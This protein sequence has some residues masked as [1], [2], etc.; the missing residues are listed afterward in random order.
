MI[1]KTNFLN[2]L[3]NL[4]KRYR[5][6]SQIWIILF[7]SAIIGIISGLGAILFH[8]ILELS[9]YFFL[10]FLAGYYP[11]GPGGEA[12]LFPELHTKIN[13]WVLL[14]IPAI[15]AGL[16]GIIVYWLAPEAE[17][18]GTDAAID[19]YHH[20][21]GDVR[22]IVPFVKIIASALTIGSGGSAGREGP[23]AQ[24]GSGFGSLLGKWLKL[25]GGQRRILM[26]AGV[27]GGI[28]AIFHAPIAG[29]LFASEVLYRNIDFEYEA[30]FPASI[31]SIIAYSVYTS[32]YGWDPLFKIP[33]FIFS[34]PLQLIP[35]LVLAV[36]LA[37]GAIL[38][39]KT[40]YGIHDLFK[41]LPVPK[42]IKPAIGGLL[43]G[44]IGFFLPEALGTGY[45]TIQNALFGKVSIIL[46]ILM[47]FAKIATT[48]FTVGSG[49]SGGIFGPA[50]V[51]GG[52]IGGVVGILFQQYFPIFQINSGTFV[53]VAS[54]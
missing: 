51:I 32:V 43:T 2:S 1:N 41:K 29:A 20:K 12:S 18:H 37:L 34:N 13:R 52:A 46:L 40:F 28:G 35:F 53:L 9:K 8:N 25:D 45:G 48:S 15:G 22:G 39:I 50:I 38:Y 44:V 7:L 47:V 54:W 6:D 14:I 19:A 16:G 23:I 36:F 17:G 26:L 24:I 10:N 11:Q 33:N 30:I 27:A 3:S 31:S 4:F 5:L 21:D 49:G 42:Y